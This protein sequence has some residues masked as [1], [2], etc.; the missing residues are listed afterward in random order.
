M[1]RSTEKDYHSP[2]SAAD[3][4]L[5]EA[6]PGGTKHRMYEWPQQTLRVSNREV[7]NEQGLVATSEVSPQRGPLPTLPAF[8]RMKTAKEFDVDAS[9]EST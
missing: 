5:T 9:K 4:K 2:P 6:T 8:A 7:R 1:T 3:K